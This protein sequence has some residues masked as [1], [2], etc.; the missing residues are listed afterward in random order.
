MSPIEVLRRRRQ[1]L[2]RLREL[3]LR[4]LVEPVADA[5]VVAEVAKLRRQILEDEESWP[6]FAPGDRIPREFAEERHA[7]GKLMQDVSQLNAQMSERLKEAR[8]DVLER[9][10]RLKGRKKPRR[11]LGLNVRA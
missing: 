2:E 8:K 11:T 3:T 6:A 9:L 1:T 7:V 5:F 10:Q 4:A